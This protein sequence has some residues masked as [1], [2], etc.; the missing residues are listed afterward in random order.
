MR[1]GRGGNKKEE[2]RKK[3]HE[4]S[5]ELFMEKGFHNTTMQDIAEKAN[6]S[7]AT[8]FNYFPSKSDIVLSFGRGQTSKLSK[9][10][11]K[12]PAE[13]GVKEQIEA[14]ILEDL[15]GTQDS[16]NLAKFQLSEVYKT[17]WLYAAETENRE[18]LAKIYSRILSKGQEEGKVSTNLDC[19]HVGGM[20]VAI[21]F[22]SLQ[23]YFEID[24]NMD[25]NSY[26][27]KSINILWEGISL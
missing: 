23:R 18:K 21:Y 9:Y 4:A 19:R 15:R 10:V 2:M 11:N 24:S 14:V 17:D 26:I 1:K 5:I 27:L 6:V 8:I 16:P 20:I 13:L 3:I 25:I 7:K 12:L 22:Y